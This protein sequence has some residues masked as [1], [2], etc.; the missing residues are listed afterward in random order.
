MAS[1]P[2]S[3]PRRR[4]RP[5]VVRRRS[6]PLRPHRRRQTPRTSAPAR[7]PP[8]NRSISDPEATPMPRKPARRVLELITTVPWAITAEALQTIIA[9]ASRDGGLDPEK[10][11]TAVYGR[12]PNPEA[13]TVKPGNL[14]AG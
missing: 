5:V 8:A 13:L 2:R 9:V 12:V 1:R 3:P 14:L 4:S 11:A 10:I 6:R 7:T